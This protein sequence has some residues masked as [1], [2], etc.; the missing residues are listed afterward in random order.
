M[1]HNWRLQ[2]ILVVESPL[3]TPQLQ[4]GAESI[5]F[6]QASWCSLVSRLST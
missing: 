3:A 1:R 4:S 6:I 2:S 5:A